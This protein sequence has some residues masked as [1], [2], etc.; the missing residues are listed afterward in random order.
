MSGESRTRQ[1]PDDLTKIIRTMEQRIKNLESSQRIGFTSFEVGEIKMIND[2]PEI[3]MFPTGPDS[4]RQVSFYAFEETGTGAD[5]GTAVTLLLEGFDDQGMRDSAGGKLIFQNN[6]AIMALNDHLG[7]FPEVYIWF[8]QPD[9]EVID[10][11]GKFNNLNQTSD[12][13]AIY[14]GQDSIGA[15]FT[16]LIHTYFQAFASTA[17]PVITLFNSAGPVSWNLTAQ[18]QSSF[19]VGWT[20]TL[21]KVVNIWVVRI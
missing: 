8:G 18:S 4:L 5:I 17:M 2:I 16:G 15:G 7:G 11:Q 19:T 1:S 13:Q 21:A 14:S 20:G 10:I 6:A 3:D 12:R 9:Y